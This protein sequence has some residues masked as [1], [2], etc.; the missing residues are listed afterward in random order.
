[1]RRSAGGKLPGSAECR[2]SFLRQR[3]D[4]RVGQVGDAIGSEVGE[5]VDLAEAGLADRL[6]VLRLDAVQA[7]DVAQHVRQLLPAF[8]DMPAERPGELAGSGGAR[9]VGLPGGRPTT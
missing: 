9:P 4:R 8:V 3:P 5:A 2:N 7:E 1:M 6:P